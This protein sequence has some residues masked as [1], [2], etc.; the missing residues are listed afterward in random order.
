MKEVAMNTFEQTLDTVMQLSL[1]Q[2][3]MLINIVRH[4]N[5]E[6]RRH[7]IAKESREA[8]AD[9]HAGKLKPQPVQDIITKLNQQ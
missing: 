3:D 9:F 8:I 4:R 2:R 7:Q 1:E 6:N 5:I